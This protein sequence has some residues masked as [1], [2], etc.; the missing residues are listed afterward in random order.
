[1]LFALSSLRGSPVDATDGR[2]G[3]VKD[4][5]FDD[6]TWKVRWL[7]VDTGAWLPGR[8]LLIHPSAIEPLDLGEPSGAGLPM[9]GMRDDLALS[10]RL[11]QRQIEDG[12]DISEHE[13]VTEQVQSM[14]YDY[15]GWDRHGGLG[16][17]G[18]NAI[19]SPLSAPPFFAETPPPGLAGREPRQ[20]GD[21]HL[22]SVDAVIGYHI[23]AT[24][25]D[26]GH[27]EN[28]LA[29]DA[30]WDI[31]YLMVATSNWWMGQHVLLA[32]FAVQSVDTA[33]SHVRLNV[34]REQVKSSPPWDPVAAVD[35]ITEQQLHRHYNWPG[36]GW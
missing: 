5:L 8:Q 2:A 32:P 22:L 21:P 31:R 26:I 36:Y 17:P 30:V 9:M 10:V 6:R 34:S 15:Y 18:M 35:R 28:F 25:G 33:D 19:A 27:V 14:V 29:D 4:F 11:T 3:T 1:M 20:A 7:V 16:L 12:P 13:P 23:H 24:D